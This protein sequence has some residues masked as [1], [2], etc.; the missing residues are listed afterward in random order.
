MAGAGVAVLLTAAPYASATDATF[1]SIP[2]PTAGGQPIGITT[3]PGGIW[4]TDAANGLVGRMN[5]DDTITE[6]ALLEADSAP[7]AIADGPDGALWFT[8][9]GTNAIGRLTPAGEAVDFPLPAVGST[10]AGIAAGPDGNVWYTLRSAHRIG[11]A[12]ETDGVSE[13]QLSGMPGPWGITAGP[14][15]AMWFTEQSA[16]A[17]GRIDVSSTAVSSIALPMPDARPGAIVTGGDGALWFTLKGTNQIGRMTTAGTLSLF[18][19]P[20]A[21]ANP[22]A[23]AA[24]PDGAIWFTETAVDK[25]G[26]LTGGGIETFPVGNAPKGITVDADG[27]AWVSV[28]D[29]GLITRITL[30]GAP[31]DTTAPSITID[32]PAWGAWTVR[33]SGALPAAYHCADETALA[34]CRGDVGDGEQVTDGTLGAHVFGVHAEDEAGNAADA[35]GSYL[36]FASAAGTLLDGAHG[37][38]WLTL[39]LG[40]DLPKGSADPLGTALMAPSDCGTGEPTSGWVPADVGTRV[41]PQGTLEVRWRTDRPWTG[42]HSLAL[43]FTAA[44]WEGPPAVFGPVAFTAAG[45]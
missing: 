42:C 32:Q 22:T 43:W 28:D 37:G 18:D 12:N 11:W 5:D 15:G 19:L 10:P 6:F 35:S 23:I 17:I 41:S 40:M 16:N 1:T 14:D 8:E 2:V 13:I 20:D 38:P 39:S 7:T 4:Y 27:D 26:R 30:D 45:V 3:G 36:V 44:G 34:V 25:V 24:A 29:D 9:S 31:A 33:G 21:A